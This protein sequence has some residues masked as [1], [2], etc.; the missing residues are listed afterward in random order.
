MTSSP[1]KIIQNQAAGLSLYVHHLVFWLSSGCSFLCI[2]I[3]YFCVLNVL[4]LWV[5]MVCDVLEN[6]QRKYFSVWSH[7]YYNTNLHLYWY[8]T[9]VMP[10]W[11]YMNLKI[12][13]HCSLG[14]C[15]EL[16]I[17]GKHYNFFVNMLLYEKPSRKAYLQEKLPNRFVTS[18]KMCTSQDWVEAKICVTEI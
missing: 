2:T 17:V 14:F 16:H 1:K 13:S 7:K 10:Q 18:V 4:A 5:L 12:Y 9:T 6:N 15:R 8:F 11:S 3:V